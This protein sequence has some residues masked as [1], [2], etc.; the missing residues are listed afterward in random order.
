MKVDGLLIRAETLQKQ[1]VERVKG[2]R[3]IRDRIISLKKTEMISLRAVHQAPA[4]P[5]CFKLEIRNYLDWIRILD[6]TLPS[7]D[8][9][10]K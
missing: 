7:G 6:T 3:V 10:I 9:Q 4:Q 8:L 2:E 1:T 5:P